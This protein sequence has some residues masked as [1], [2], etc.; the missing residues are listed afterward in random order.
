[1][2]KEK[3]IKLIFG[4]VEKIFWSRGLSLCAFSLKIIIVESEDMYKEWLFFIWRMT[5]KL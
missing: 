3:L 4:S 5:K 2:N 1:M